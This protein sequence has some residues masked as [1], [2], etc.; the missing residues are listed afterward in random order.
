MY[1]LSAT[2]SLWQGIT[3]DSTV[4]VGGCPW[5]E[6]IEEWSPEPVKA[7]IPTVQ[8]VW[9]DLPQDIPSPVILFW[10]A[11]TNL[12]SVARK[13]NSPVIITVKHSA[14]R[15]GT[16]KYQS[17]RQWR[18]QYPFEHTK[19][20]FC[21][22][23]AKLH[24]QP[25]HW[26][27][28][29]L[30]L[31]FAI[32]EQVCAHWVSGDTPLGAKDAQRLYSLER[33]FFAIAYQR[34][35]LVINQT[36][37]P[38]SG[39]T[40]L[41]GDSSDDDLLEARH[42]P[43]SVRVTHPGSLK[44][45]AYPTE[46]RE[47]QKKREKKAKEKGETL[48]VKKRKKYVEDH[49]DDCGEDISSIAKE[50]DL[51][52][53]TV[54]AES[55][56]DS[57][58]DDGTYLSFM[59]WGSTVPKE[60][61]PHPQVINLQDITE[62]LTLL[63]NVGGGIDIAE[64]CGGEGRPS[65]LAIRRRLKVGRN[66]DL[67][68]NVDLN[69]PKDQQLTK[70]YIN[71]NHVL[72]V[73]MAPTCGPFGPMGQLNRKLHPSSWQRAY[74]NA[75]PHG[76]FCGEIAQLQLRKGRHFICEQPLGSTLYLEQP[77]PQVL[78]QSTVCQQKYDRCMAGLKAQSGP[79]KGMYIRK[80]ST[81]TASNPILI[82]H[83]VHL[84]CSGKHAHLQMKG[85]AENLSACQVWTWDEA[86][87]VVSGISDL[88][89][90]LKSSAGHFPITVSSGSQA[91]PGQE[92]L[93]REVKPRGRDPDAVSPEQ[94]QCLGCRYRRARANPAH[95]RIK[96]ECGYPY[97]EPEYWKCEG[98]QH[99]RPKTSNTHTFLPGECRLTVTAERR[100][101]PRKGHHP[102]DP[103]RR[104]SDD[105]TAMLDP[106]DVQQEPAHEEPEMPG[107]SSSS[108]P[109][110]GPD[111]QARTRRTT[112]D[113]AVGSTEPTDWV[114]FDVGST[115]RAMRVGNQATQKRLLRK[116]HLRW[117]HASTQAMTTTLQRAGLPREI[118]TMIPDIVD[119]C[120][121]CRQW[122]QPLPHSVASVN[123]P[124][125]FNQ[126][127][128]CD[129]VFIEKK[130]VIHFVDRCTR[131]H[132]ASVIQDRSETSFMYA[133][134]QTWLAIHG[135][136]RELIMDGERGVAESVRAASF[137][138]RHGIQLVPRA[139]NQHAQIVE[140]RGALLKDVIHRIMGQLQREGIS[141]DMPFEFILAEAVFAGNALVSV[142]NTT[143]YNAVYGRVPSI[144]PDINQAN[145]NDA[146]ADSDDVTHPGLLRHTHRLREIAV[147][148]MVEG[149][150]RA[151]LGRALNTKTLPAAQAENYQVGEEVDF[152]RPPHNKDIP[153]WTGPAVITDLTRTDRGVIGIRH[154]GRNMI[155]KPG[156]LRRHL[157]FLCFEAAILSAT[158]HSLGLL[159]T[160]KCTV[161]KLPTGTI[162]H[163]GMM[164]YTNPDGI[165]SWRKSPASVSNHR[166]LGNLLQF[167]V[168]C[169]NLENC[170]AVRIAKGIGTLPAING[171][172]DSLLVWWH[173]S[174][175]EQVSTYEYNSSEKLN[176]RLF[177]PETWSEIR[178]IQF[179][180][181][182]DV[183]TAEPEAVVIN[184]RQ[185]QEP[186]TISVRDQAVQ[187]TE[188]SAQQAPAPQPAE[189]MGNLSPIP[190][191]NSQTPSVASDPTDAYF[192]Q[193]E[194]D[195]RQAAYKAYLACLQETET[196]ERGEIDTDKEPFEA[197]GMFHPP[198]G[199]LPEDF[200]HILHNY[201]ITAANRRANLPLNHGCD[202]EPDYV[203]IFYAGL[204][205]KLVY[206]R[207]R[208]PV[209]GEVLVQRLYLTG[210]RRAVVQR[211]DDTLTSEELK[212]H[213]KEVAAAMLKELL[214]WAKL[215]CFSRKK[216]Q[217]ARN[218]IDCRW[219]IK[220]KHELAATSVEDASN[221]TGG[222]ATTK[223][224]IR[225]RLTVR[226]FKDR[227]AQSL[228]SYAGTSQRYSQRLVCSEA[229]HRG[230]PIC[231]TDISKAFLQGVTYKELSEQ[232]G[233]PI[234]EVNFYLPS[235]CNDILRQVPGFEDFNENSEV[236][237]C[238][239]PGT[240]L[241]DAPRAFSMKLALVTKNK[242]RM[243]P[244]TVDGEL[245][246]KFENGKLLCLMAKHVD[247]LKLTGERKIIE[248][249]LK[250]IQD[251]FGELKI[252]WHSFTN[253]GL[254]HIQDPGTFGI[255]LDQE[256]YVKNLKPIIHGD[257]KG[258]SSE[259]E[260]SPELT[261]LFMSLLG[262][263]AYSLMT[264]IDIAVFVCALQRV[265]HKPKIIHI[266][267]LN[268]VLRWMQANPKRLTFK[269]ARGPSHLRCVGD[270]AFKREEEAGHS[271]R[272][273]LFL[274]SFG[275][276][277]TKPTSNHGSSE[278]IT[279]RHSS[280]EIITAQNTSAYTT[281]AQVHIVDAICKSQRHVTRSTFSSEL[282]SACD[283]IDHGMLLALSLHEFTSGPQ[284]TASARQLREFGG[285]DVKLSLFVDAMSVYAAVTATFIKIPAEKSL[286]S[287][288][289]Y[290]RELLDTKVLEAL[291]WI[292][293]RDMVADGLT[294]GAVDRDALH[295]CMAGIWQIT[296]T[297]KIWSAPKQ[298]P[299]RHLL[300]DA[301]LTSASSAAAAQA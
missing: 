234:R 269:P 177:L 178:I 209:E 206:N 245:V 85:Q 296:H 236:L 163:L 241:V 22:Y 123:I 45:I 35:G 89:R 17:F 259:K 192:V 58:D 75:A 273:A 243:I 215:K 12:V 62:L 61:T 142:N 235:H 179:L 91:T 1:A 187:P 272:G 219:V 244:S 292:D 191:E 25:F 146:P 188:Q 280:S 36:D 11:L 258:Q 240:G 118:I 110:R 291:I 122:M 79:Y 298:Q 97:D 30:S 59:L 197:K 172:T 55:E 34:F 253:C 107:A 27:M 173:P 121:V 108:Q 65:T 267:R 67:V 183:E 24:N 261:Q 84:Q 116:L 105:P 19:H 161:E 299:P 255:T 274:R 124:D 162:T 154:Q 63:T 281:S 205:T 257:L 119:T 195:L 113:Q 242:C 44:E 2:K 18:K 226:G 104:A 268:A 8:M 249:I 131:W 222:Q 286:L 126:Q 283:T 285:W 78:N 66:F 101:A 189:R 39:T 279:A 180:C 230:W 141:H 167:S 16:W 210:A 7:T 38:D 225:A 100:S 82:S 271:L 134:N 301:P 214:T 256:E 265:T 231:T 83:F 182:T 149:T 144:L 133:I 99:D 109:A 260:C 166:D 165:T 29:V 139:P 77:W 28:N 238:D 48:A 252:E 21:M 168:R 103:R 297:A 275:G 47:R 41:Q 217:G 94:S 64:L 278:I 136:M 250:Q 54:E 15:D 5:S 129:V 254:R 31:G 264:R 160:V 237:H 6:F 150:A 46:A 95:N 4:N 115:L 198:S 196:I 143:P 14:T 175:S 32:T 88:K 276:I 50:Q 200:K 90:E 33:F 152:Y 26:K 193:E 300:S 155:C 287:H 96:G 81:M 112:Q 157:S 190:E 159:P 106:A 185:R 80:S 247:D 181:A 201:H 23:G 43:E 86:N 223:R 138:A 153:G 176:M 130:S 137:L 57:S 135:P 232:T 158:D 132:A 87:R 174:N 294:K 53:H 164:Q 194:P 76:R 199:N 233:E 9:I 117:W 216:R 20:C 56:A 284:S 263:V 71:D 72:V 295:S 211:D 74:D 184:D 10:T 151:R 42:G 282:L 111:Q 147:Q 266:K 92:S 148:Q 145:A 40:T 171:Y 93:G 169:L 212:T 102:R 213:A 203:E 262:A 170:I 293:T 60:I 220:W 248:E 227:D 204:A 229:A 208:T 228:D 270:A 289:Q 127:V 98:C 49:H 51:H 3:R 125:K 68:T 37:V 202:E 251:V 52:F 69:R 140:R 218:I 246:L 13:Q 239:K 221:R 290:L 186:D 120:A 73:I 70:Q 277:T 114:S 207:E 156:D 224:V 288:I 128:E